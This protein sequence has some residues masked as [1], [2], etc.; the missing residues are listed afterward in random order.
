MSAFDP[1]MPILVLSALKFSWYHFPYWLT[2][3]SALWRLLGEEREYI[4]HQQH[5]GCDDKWT[6]L[7]A[8]LGVIQEAQTGVNVDFEMTASVYMSLAVAFLFCYFAVKFA[9][10]FNVAFCVLICGITVEEKIPTFTSR[11]ELLNLNI[12]FY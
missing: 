6:D 11:G 3:S 8:K 1:V 5:N 4:C 9:I 2:M 7:E 10:L 12:P